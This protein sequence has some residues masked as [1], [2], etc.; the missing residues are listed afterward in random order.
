M[1]YCQALGALPKFM[2]CGKFQVILEALITAS[3]ITK[4]EEKWAQ[5]R[6]DAIKAITRYDSLCE[7]K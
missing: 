7:M 6:R 2:I 3:Q 5:A 1:G 4:K